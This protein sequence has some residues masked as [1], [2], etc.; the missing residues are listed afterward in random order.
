MSEVTAPMIEPTELCDLLAAASGLEQNLTDM[1]P[2]IWLFTILEYQ[3]K[4]ALDPEN[5]CRNSPIIT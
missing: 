1:K 5:G 3:W 2:L 4:W